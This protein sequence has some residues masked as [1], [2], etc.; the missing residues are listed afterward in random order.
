[1][2]TTSCL[3]IKAASLLA[4]GQQEDAGEI[5]RQALQLL[6]AYHG[7][8]PYFPQRD[9]WMCYETLHALQRNDL[10]NHAVALARQHLLQQVSRIQNPQRRASFLDQVS[11]NRAIY[12]TIQ[13]GVNS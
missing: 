4:L 3:A 11:F 5:A 6:D 13:A 1:M 7:E 2:L 12:Q 10:A 9:Y 8:G